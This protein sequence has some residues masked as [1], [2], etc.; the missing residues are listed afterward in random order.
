MGEREGEYAGKRFPMKSELQNGQIYGLTC[1]RVERPAT[2][3]TAAEQC[4]ATDK[5]RAG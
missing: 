2:W 5:V 3:F 4:D 1:F